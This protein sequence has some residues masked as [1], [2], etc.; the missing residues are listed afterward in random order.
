MPHR[1][2]NHHSHAPIDLP[3]TEAQALATLASE[4]PDAVRAVCMEVL[5]SWTQPASLDILLEA[6]DDGSHAVRAAARRA[7]WQT[8][9]R[10]ALGV[11]AERLTDADGAVDDLGVRAFFLVDLDTAF[12]RAQPYLTEAAVKTKAGLAL[13]EALLDSVSGSGGRGNYLD[14]DES[15]AEGDR[16]KRA[17]DD[18]F[19]EDT[20]EAREVARRQALLARFPFRRDPRWGDVALRFLDHK[21][22]SESAL[23]IVSN[24]ADRRATAPLLER[25]RRDC[26]NYEVST[27]LAAIGDPATAPAVI[28]ML[29]DR[30]IGW[31]AY[32]VLGRLRSPAALDVLVARLSELEAGDGVDSILEALAR[33]NDPRAVLPIAGALTRKDVAMYPLAALRALWRLD[34]PDAL[35]ALRASRDRLAKAASTAKTRPAKARNAA[36]TAHH[37]RLIAHL[38][39]DRNH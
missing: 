20:E 32:H 27:A 34:S 23:R 25:L 17:A 36:L 28:A 19:A 13:A 2:S 31:A 15:A 39:R 37:D 14:R 33:I 38:E 8:R 1:P 24:L 21:T 30:T 3:R 9:D 35:P 12:E 5:T 11:L 6:S 22:L 10:R 29:D 7:L 16:G 18:P 26:K 4:P